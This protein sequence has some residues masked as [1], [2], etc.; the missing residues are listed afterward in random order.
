MP[1]KLPGALGWRAIA[2]GF[3]SL[4]RRGG[5]LGLLRGLGGRRGV[6]RLIGRSCVGSG[7]FLLKRL[8]RAC[9]G[10]VGLGG[11]GR[12]LDCWDRVSG[13]LVDWS[14]WPGDGG[15]KQGPCLDWTGLDWVFA[16]TDR[17]GMGWGGTHTL[18][19]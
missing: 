2:S 8:F 3:Q 5:G 7:G 17:V 1:R 16:Q 6:L 18:Y 9:S 14:G 19:I 4:V 10:G 13:W 11:L 15:G 12:R